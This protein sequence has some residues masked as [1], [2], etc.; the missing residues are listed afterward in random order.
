MESMPDPHHSNGSVNG[1]FVA[2]NKPLPRGPNVQTSVAS[3]PLPSSQDSERSPTSATSPATTP[4]YWVQS[5]RR[6]VS[7]VSIESIVNGGITLQDNTDGQNDKN[8]ACWAKAVHIDDHVVING[9]RTGIG[10]FVVWNIT[11]DTLHV[12]LLLSLS[13]HLLESVANRCHLFRE[14][15]YSFASVSPNSMIYVIAFFKPFLSLKPLCPL[16]PLK[17]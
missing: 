5:H 6:S 12:S 16:S 13:L 15:P 11:I 9:S 2:T 7:N 14:A 4:P 8:D 17:V 3:P 10:A 1:C